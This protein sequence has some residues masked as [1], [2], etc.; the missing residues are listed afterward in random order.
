M[1]KREK[2]LRREGRFDEL[3]DAR[4]AEFVVRGIDRAEQQLAD[5]LPDLQSLARYD[6]MISMTYCLQLLKLLKKR[7]RRRA[8]GVAWE[9]DAC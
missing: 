2:K 4:T 8:D 3:S 9:E 1:P 7:Y 6:D 5:L